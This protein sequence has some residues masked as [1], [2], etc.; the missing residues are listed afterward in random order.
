MNN[1]VI[2]GIGLVTPLGLGREKC[3]NQLLLSQSAAAPDILNPDILTAR[4]QG[5]NILPETRML[6]MAFLA[7]AEAL[8]DSALSPL[9]IDYSKFGCTLSSSKPNL[10]NSNMNYNI[11]SPL[12]IG[13]SKVCSPTGMVVEGGAE[14]RGEGEKT[15]KTINP[16]PQSSPARGEELNCKHSSN[17]VFSDT[18]LQS[19][20]GAQVSRVLRLR[21]RIINV[22]AACATGAVS[23]IEAARLIE[24]GDCDAVIA[25]AVEA[26]FH[27][28]YVAGFSQMGV[29]A[30]NI[31]C[32]FDKKR[33]GFAL[34][35]GAGALILERKE[36]AVLRGARIYGE[37]SGWG[38]SC[39]T[40]D[41]VSYDNSGKSI[42]LAVK[43][44]LEMS[45]IDSVGYINAH[46]TGTRLNDPM[47][48]RAYGAAFGD[49]LKDIPVSSTKAAT[50]HL[51][52]ASGAVE[53]AFCLLTLRDGTLPPTLNLTDPD[54]D[55]G[56]YHIPHRPLDKDINSAMSVS[57]GFGG[58]T[59]AICVKKT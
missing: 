3:W 7:A 49:K 8:S 37:L 38:M 58:Q 31:V 12:M 54:K 26:P 18:F 39:D 19:T 16:S 5:L 20:V 1:I 57:Y 50:G 51:L 34:G 27:P 56:L 10:L 21:G 33:E 23:I 55:C 47:E 2:T 36:I 48:T 22:S 32:P 11:P 40:K 42:T 15:R 44:A 30:K 28:L 9:I 43:K 52:G 4:I 41:P 53:A 14:G 59:A 13:G 29:L 17:I 6:S 35:E 25:G 45:G 46:G 24:N